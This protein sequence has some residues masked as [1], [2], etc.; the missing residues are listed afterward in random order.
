PTSAIAVDN[1]DSEVAYVGTDVGVYRTSDGGASWTSFQER[2]PRS[3][4]TELRL[5]R[6][7]R[8]LF[9][10]TMGRGVYSRPI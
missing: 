6:S 4:I 10:A 5:H 3:P 7:G 8:L 1:L 2:L 9:A